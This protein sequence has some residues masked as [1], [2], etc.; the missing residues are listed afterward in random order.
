M[1][2]LPDLEQYQR[3]VRELLTAFHSGSC[4]AL[5]QVRWNHPN[6]Q[7]QD[8][9]TLVQAGLDA[10]DAQAVIAKMNG[11]NHWEDVIEF[12]R[13]LAEG[14]PFT[15]RFEQAANAIVT[16]EIESLRVLLDQHADLIRQRSSRAHHSTLLH[17]V[18]ANGVERERQVTPDS[19]LEITRLLLKT[20]ANV[21]AHS[22][23]YGGGSTVLGLVTTSAHPRRKGVQIPLMDL[24]LEH[25][26]RIDGDR[27]LP[28][29]VRGALAN[30]CPEAARALAQR[31]QSLPTLFAAAGAGQLDRVQER[32]PSASLGER[33]EALLVAAQ[34][35]HLEIV[36]FLLNQGVPATACGDLPALHYACAGGH[37]PV[38]QLLLARG[39]DLEQLNV[40]GGTTLGSTLWFA[41]HLLDD[42]FRRIDF[43]RIIQFL[44]DTGAR[45]DEIPNL[46]E[47]LAHLQSR[48]LKLRSVGP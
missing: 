27:D 12:T 18:S 16:G 28:N 1:N 25:G 40:F 35:G 9:Q 38:I 14:D 10:S 47:E 44:I 20:G 4:Q 29:L 26:A 24:L 11:F 33:T 46:S 23:A 3:A 8:N 7:G 6:R 32:F 43:L 13:R 21:N 2:P 22:D 42:E 31:G 19:I 45:T 39:A 41:H 34:E 15:V 17:Y 30:G 37:W 48:A 5:D 36:E